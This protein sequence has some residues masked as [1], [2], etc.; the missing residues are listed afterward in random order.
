M[1]W[2]AAVSG[3]WARG[4]GG[5]IAARGGFDSVL[6]VVLGV[7]SLDVLAKEQIALGRLGK[8]EEIAETVLYL[9]RAGYTTGQVITVDGGFII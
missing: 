6:V 5:G 7:E 8:A 2:S 4:G 9:A 1:N 3:S